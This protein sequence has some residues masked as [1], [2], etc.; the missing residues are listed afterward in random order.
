MVTCFWLCAALV[1][2]AYAGYP[3]LLALAARLRPARPRRGPVAAS[4]SVIIAAH[5]EEATITHRLE[6]FTALIAAA[7]I[8]GEVIVV[9][10]GSTDRTAELARAFPKGNVRV[11]ELPANSGKA[12]ALNVGW[13]VSAHEILVFA[14]TRQSWHPDALRLLLENFAD[15]TVGAVSGDLVVEGPGGILAGV[16]LYWRYEKWLRRQESRVHSAVGVTGAISAVR[17]SLYRRIP[18]GLI[19]DDV[20]WPLRVT[21][22]GYRVVHDGRAHAFDR[23]P[24]TAR[25]EFRRK[26]RTLTGNFQLVSRLPAALLPWRNPVWFELLSHKLLR[27]AVPWALVA[28]LVLSAFLPGPLYQALFWG[29]AAGYLVALAGLCPGL[30]RF[31]LPA[32]GASFVVLNAAAW[33]AFW[34]WISGKA[35]RSWRKVSYRLKPAGNPRPVRDLGRPGGWQIPI[36][37][38]GAAAG[39]IPGRVPPENG[40]PASS[41]E[42]PVITAPSGLQG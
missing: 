22:Q 8:P 15:P 40:V 42:A 25:D 20:Y 10:D 36:P 24:E 41:P 31:R 7:G 6:E 14:D 1:V 35:G 18:R 26:V 3:L 28:M 2:Y 38:P 19:V 37:G 32:A 34:V 4:V 27:L 29:Q 11:L 23:L 17:R 5:N 9:S 12:V 21:M 33:V 39:N 30:S 13:A 16:G